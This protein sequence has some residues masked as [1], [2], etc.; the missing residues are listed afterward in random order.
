M[1]AI[2]ATS[3]STCEK[4]G[5]TVASTARLEAGFHLRSTPASPRSGPSS[6]GVPSPFVGSLVRVV[7]ANGAT[8]RWEPFGRAVSPTSLV[9][10]QMKQFTSRGSRAEKN[11]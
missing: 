5:F 11:W 1:A 3:D 6:R 4:S 10:L 8:T 2:W 7:V 9:E